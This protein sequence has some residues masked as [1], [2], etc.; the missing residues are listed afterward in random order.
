MALPILRQ[1]DRPPA[2]RTR[3]CL[4]SGFDVARDD[5]Q[6]ELPLVG[7][8]LVAYLALQRRPVS[9][10]AVAGV[11][12]PESTQ[13]RAQASLRSALWRVRRADG[14]MVCSLNQC[15][16][17]AEHVDCDV[18]AVLDVMHHLDEGR[19]PPSYREI[20]IAWFSA[21]LLPDWC[22]DWVSLERERFRLMALHA[23]EAMSAWHLARQEFG[24]AIE[25]ALAAVRLE[26]LR[27]TAQR[28]LLKAHLAQGNVSEAVRQYR[29]Y[30]EL[31]RAELGVG[32]SDQMTALL[33]SAGLPT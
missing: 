33:S 1:V 6:L 4:L 24:V 12:W 14:E 9:R 30:D 25:T 19:E 17:L 20:P 11:L 27:E 28:A 22:D 21:E 15:L 32:P 8:R 31:L 7:A 18:D 10:S 3:V 13:E 2:R 26:P 23:L 5:R 29:R 16:A